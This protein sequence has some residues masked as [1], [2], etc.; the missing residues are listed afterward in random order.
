MAK[1]QTPEPQAMTVADLEAAEAKAKAE[2]AAAAEKKAA[3]LAEADS[4]ATQHA[5]AIP[6]LQNASILHERLGNL[7]LWTENTRTTPAGT[8]PDDILRESLACGWDVRFPAVIFPDRRVI[9]GNRR[10]A[11]LLAQGTNPD[12]LIPCV[13]YEG[14]E[15]GAILISLN[16]TGTG[17][18]EK[19]AGD[20]ERAAVR[21]MDVHGLSAHTLARYLWKRSRETLIALSPTVAQVDPAN[22]VAVQAACRSRLQGLEDIRALP[23]SVREAVYAEHNSGVRKGK[24]FTRQNIAELAKTCKSSGAAACQERM[25]EM[26]A[27]AE[28]GTE[29]DDSNPNRL[30]AKHISDNG[31]RYKSKA[32]PA[33]AALMRKPE[34]GEADRNALALLMAIDKALAEAGQ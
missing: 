16:D 9:Q 23:D 1:K 20:V 18:A 22:V 11:I 19:N 31:G 8:V 30:T 5:L 26:Q 29:A 32:L 24:A 12:T 34:E 13:V 10:I 21:L 27:A 17:I 33:L 7:I 15:A 28:Q 4:I 3:K 2:K 25:A 6:A 14:D